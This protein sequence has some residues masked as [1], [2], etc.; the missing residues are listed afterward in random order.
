MLTNFLF[1]VN[2]YADLVPTT[3]PSLN[4]FKW[5]RQINGVPFNSEN[6]Q[7]IQVLPSATTSNIVPY[8]FSTVQASGVAN[9]VSTN[10]ATLTGST[11]GIAVGQLIVGTGIP[12]G[13]TIVSITGLAI[14]M[15]QAATITGSTTLS[16]YT[17]AAFLY[18]ESD[19]QVSMIYNNGTPMVLNPFEVNGIT[20]PA[21]FFMAGAVYS[22]TVTNM[23]ATTANV[24][25]ASMG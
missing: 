21:V 6:D 5:S 2:A 9:I 22:L 14:T 1:Y 20:Q 19:Q 8:P 23:S 12:V 24:F 11:P 18:M 15:S 3:T 4:N 16:F 7:Q 17:P 13:T 25:F 10:I